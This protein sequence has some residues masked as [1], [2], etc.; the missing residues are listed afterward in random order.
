MPTKIQAKD[1]LD[2]AFTTT[3][4]GPALNVNIPRTTSWADMDE[5]TFKIDLNDVTAGAMTLDLN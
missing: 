4:V 2:K 3:G 5:A 1:F